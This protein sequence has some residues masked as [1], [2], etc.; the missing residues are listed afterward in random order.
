MR[1]TKHTIRDENSWD[2]FLHLRN[3]TPSVCLSAW[4][5]QAFVAAPQS[6]WA[7]PLSSRPAPVLGFGMGPIC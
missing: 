7:E 5:S 6:L 3:R 1:E 2:P 4:G